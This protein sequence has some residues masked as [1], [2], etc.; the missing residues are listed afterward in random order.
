V[1]INSINENKTENNLFK[2]Y[3]NPTTNFAVIEY[4]LLQKSIVSLEIY[5]LLGKKIISINEGQKETGIYKQ[6]LNFENLEV[7]EGLY[8]IMLSVDDKISSQKILYQK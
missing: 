5:N 1:G 4:E 3:P 2:I 7:A 6:S 8:L